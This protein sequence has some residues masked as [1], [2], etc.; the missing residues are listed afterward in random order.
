M[1]IYTYIYIYPHTHFDIC[2]H[3][4]THIYLYTGSRRQRALVTITG[5][6]SRCHGMTASMPKALYSTDEI[7]MRGVWMGVWLQ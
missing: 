5:M 6:L 4:Y 7:H 2:I 1:Y 3:T